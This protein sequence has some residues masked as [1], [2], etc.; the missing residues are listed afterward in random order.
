MNDI[1]ILFQFLCS[2][3]PLGSAPS[4]LSTSVQKYVIFINILKE[5]LL[6]HLLLCL[7]GMLMR[8]LLYSGTLIS[9]PLPTLLQQTPS[10]DAFKKL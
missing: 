6:Q 1:N 7:T 2:K 3:C 10:V 5:Q 9:D 8:G 4:A